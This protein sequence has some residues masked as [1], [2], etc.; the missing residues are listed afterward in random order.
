M[1]YMDGMV[2]LCISPAASCLFH[3][4]PPSPPTAS[5]TSN[6]VG[7]SYAW[8]VCFD[9]FASCV[10]RCLRHN[11]VVLITFDNQTSG[12]VHEISCHLSMLK[13]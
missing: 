8:L 10:S 9:W 13:I 6:L 4:Y 3:V 1:P 7:R 11:L 12:E 2:I 5:T